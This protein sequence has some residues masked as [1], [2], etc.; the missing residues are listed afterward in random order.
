MEVEGAVAKA[1]GAVAVVRALQAHKQHHSTC[2]VSWVDLH[3]SILQV[4]RHPHNMIHVQSLYCTGLVSSK[5][6]STIL[7]CTLARSAHQGLHE[8]AD[9]AIAAKGSVTEH[10]HK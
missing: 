2:I 9:S 4:D 6:C 1:T 10:L 8:P 7:I 3:I 5:D